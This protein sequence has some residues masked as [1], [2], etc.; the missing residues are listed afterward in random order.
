[1]QQFGG[2]FHTRSKLEAVRRYLVEYAKITRKRRLRTVYIDAFAGAGSY[3]PACRN[4]NTGGEDCLIDLEPQ[5]FEGSASIALQ[6]KPRFDEYVF[7]EKKPSNYACLKELRDEHPTLRASVRLM[8]G[9]ANERLRRI[10]ER[11]DW[12]QRR[13]IVFLDPFGM[14][15]DWATIEAIAHTKA[16]DLWYLFPLGA[17]S[18]LLPRDGQIDSANASKLN[19]FFGGHHWYNAFF[20][21]RVKEGLV[22]DEHMTVRVKPREEIGGYYVNRLRSIFTGVARRPRPLYSQG[23]KTLFWLCF[24]T[25]DEEGAPERIKIAESILARP[26]W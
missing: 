17:V 20:A 26:V 14:Q 25:C 10:C 19:R 5:E 13:A 11:H 21:E 9:D 6:V 24:A 12:T 16:I 22:W 15:V 23:K 3:V 7:I 1:M 8:R 2:E 4:M 18:R